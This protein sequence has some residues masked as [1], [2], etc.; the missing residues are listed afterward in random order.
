VR[1]QSRGEETAARVLDAALGLHEER[2]HAG[3]TVHAIAEASGVSLG[4]LY[5]H[6]GS[7]DGISAALYVGCMSRLMSS[8]VA[9]VERTKTA[10][11]GI[12]ALTRAYLAFTADHSNEARFIHA[13]S[14]ATFLPTHVDA[15]Q[16]A[17]AEPIAKLQR[18]LA[19]HVRSGEIVDLAPPLFEMLVIG[20]VAETARRWL[21]GG[22]H[23][24][25]LAEASRVLPERIWRSVAA[26]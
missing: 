3:F 4:S 8:L 17:K 1:K 23:G 19:P 25:D 20:P 7:V 6:F 9:D 26:R 15:I 13:S 11:T 22:S 16:A 24:I 21:A 10:K 18:W 5:H 14:Y 2:G 12:V